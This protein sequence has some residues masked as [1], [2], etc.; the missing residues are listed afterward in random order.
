[1]RNRA[2]EVVRVAR[3]QD[4]RFATHRQ[5]D[6]ALDDH[7]ALL[8]R[9]RQH[10]LA[11]VRAG[12]IALVQDRHAA[13]GEAAA[14]EPQLHRPGADIGELRSRKEDLHL[15]GEVQ[16]EELRERHG[17][18]VEHLLE[19]GHRG[20]HAVLLDERNEA[21]GH[22]RALRQLALRKAVHLP[23]GFEVSTD[24]QTHSVNYFKQYWPKIQLK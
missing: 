21:V 17:D 1:M 7:A 5:L 16:G 3:R 18:T 9:V 12:R 23:H 14:D 15:A 24:V 19:R 11:R 6:A 2:L 10:L 22:P 8:A 4:A 13:L 20:A